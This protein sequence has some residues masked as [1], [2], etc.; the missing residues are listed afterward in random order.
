MLEILTINN[1]FENLVELCAHQ[2][3]RVMQRAA[4]EP[5]YTSRRSDVVRIIGGQVT[6]NMKQEILYDTMVIREREECDF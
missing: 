5:I 2:D 3:L 4:C 1:A 6:A